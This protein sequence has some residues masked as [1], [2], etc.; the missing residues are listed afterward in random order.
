LSGD[1]QDNF[2]MLSGDEA[3]IAYDSKMWIGVIRP[4]G[5]SHFGVLRNKLKWL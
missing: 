5:D 2:E 1:G 3:L 4:G